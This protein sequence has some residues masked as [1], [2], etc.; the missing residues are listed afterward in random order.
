MYVTL[1]VN[2]VWWAQTSPKAVGHCFGP[3]LRSSGSPCLCGAIRQAIAAFSIPFEGPQTRIEGNACEGE[4]RK[5]AEARRG[6][7]C[8]RGPT[9]VSTSTF[10]EHSPRPCEFWRPSLQEDL[11]TVNPF[12]EL[13]SFDGVLLLLLCLLLCRCPCTSREALPD[14]LQIGSPQAIAFPVL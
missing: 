7:C 3:R 4:I 11:T 2:H 10:L 13:Q 1:C 14:K 9:F 8:R 5:D 12:G 6:G